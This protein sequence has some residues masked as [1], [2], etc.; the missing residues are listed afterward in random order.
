MHTYIHTYQVLGVCLRVAVG[1]A[2]A[3]MLAAE[4]ADHAARHIDFEVCIY[5]V[6]VCMY[7]C[8]DT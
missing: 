5:V 7:V 1:A 3:V 8:W 6:C 2:A 4:D